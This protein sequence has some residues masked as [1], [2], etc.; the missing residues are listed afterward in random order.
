MVGWILIDV[1]T[2]IALSQGKNG[3]P[4][5]SSQFTFLRLGKETTW[6]SFL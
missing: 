5:T 4:G 6:S 3:L 2:K 1:M